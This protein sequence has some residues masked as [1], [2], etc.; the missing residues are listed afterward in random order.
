MGCEVWGKGGVS[1]FFFF[2]CVCALRLALRWEVLCVLDCIWDFGVG[3][4]RCFVFWIVFGISVWDLV[5]ALCI[6][7]LEGSI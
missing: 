6:V 5:G 7:G 2:F 1:F 3:F 4:G